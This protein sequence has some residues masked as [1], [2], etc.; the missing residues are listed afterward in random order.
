[1]IGP[2]AGGRNRIAVEPIAS[3]DEVEEA[4]LD[5]SGPLARVPP[6]APPERVEVVGIAAAVD[7]VA[8]ASAR[9]EALVI[10]VV[11]GQN[12]ADAVA[13]EERDPPRDHLAM[14]AVRAAFEG[15]MVEDGE[16][17]A[18]SRP[19]LTVD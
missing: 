5:A 19:G 11:P 2:S 14:R 10:V 17:P 8:N 13:L 7:D 3:H 6:P 16:L 18:G 4:V 1:M 15:R 9:C 12:Q